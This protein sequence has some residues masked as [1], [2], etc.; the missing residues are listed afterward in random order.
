MPIAPRSRPPGQIHRTYR[1]THH[2]QLTLIPGHASLVSAGHSDQYRPFEGLLILHLYVR[3]KTACILVS[4]LQLGP[5]SAES[6]VTNSRLASQRCRRNVRAHDD[7]VLVV[8]P[9]S[10]GFRPLL[11]QRLCRSQ[12]LAHNNHTDRATLYA[13]FSGSLSRAAELGPYARSGSVCRLADS[14]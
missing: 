12:E 13:H 5:C 4:C 3:S 10:L 11:I 8:D 14:C 2:R 1:F 9:T 7:R 6:A